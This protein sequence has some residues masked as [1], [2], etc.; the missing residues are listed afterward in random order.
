MASKNQQENIESSKLAGTK[1]RDVVL[2]II[3]FGAYSACRNYKRARKL[4]ERFIKA[5]D[6]DGDGYVSLTDQEKYLSEHGIELHTITFSDGVKAVRNISIFEA[7]YCCAAPSVKRTLDN[8][9][10]K[11]FLREEKAENTKVLSNCQ[12]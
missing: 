4:Y 9:E 5:A 8:L 7:D 12:K 11:L 2:N 6:T 10:E 1:L 3:T